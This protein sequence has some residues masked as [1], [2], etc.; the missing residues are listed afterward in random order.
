[1]TVTILSKETVTSEGPSELTPQNVVY[2]SHHAKEVKGSSLNKAQKFLEL[3]LVE[4]D[5]VT[6]M[7]NVLPIK[8]YNTRTYDIEKKATGFECNCQ[9]CQT[10][11]KKG[12]YDP[13]TSDIAACSHIL[14][15]YLWLKIKNFNQR[16]E[17][18]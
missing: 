2:Y 6:K 5:S 14:A 9:C 17:G 1:M 18:E 16:Q 10:K 4:W 13:D 7:F 8:G 15:V 3:G 12:E 11:I